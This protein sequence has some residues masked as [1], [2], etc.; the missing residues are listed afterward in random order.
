[1]LVG[2]VARVKCSAT[3][4][5]ILGIKWGNMMILGAIIFNIVRCDHGIVVVKENVLIF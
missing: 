1:M 4:K 5:D 2:Q 3:S